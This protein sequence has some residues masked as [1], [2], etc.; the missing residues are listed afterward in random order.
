MVAQGL[1]QYLKKKRHTQQK[2]VKYDREGGREGERERE[3]ER[4]KIC[5]N[6]AFQDHQ[7]IIHLSKMNFSNSAGYKLQCTLL[8]A[9][10][11][12]LFNVCKIT[13]S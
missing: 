11:C 5:P 8:Q 6:L 4:G 12:T 3:R 1:V 7:L 10:Y 9:V 13:S 2:N